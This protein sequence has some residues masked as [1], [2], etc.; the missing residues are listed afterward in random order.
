MPHA[1]LYFKDRADR[2]R[3]F[4]SY[5]IQGNSQLRL[6]LYHQQAKRI[7]SEIALSCASYSL[8]PEIGYSDF[9]EWWE[10]EGVVEMFAGGSYG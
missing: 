2:D 5:S 3:F 9:A 7:F 8:K 10:T 4:Y 6:F 1:K